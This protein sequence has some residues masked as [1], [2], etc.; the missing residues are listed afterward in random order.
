MK[1]VDRPMLELNLRVNNYR[2][3]AV[4]V[5]VA[6]ATGATIAL[7]SA[8]TSQAKSGGSTYNGLGI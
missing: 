1:Q 4:A 6:V 3:S 8:V 2:Y 7:G 5:A